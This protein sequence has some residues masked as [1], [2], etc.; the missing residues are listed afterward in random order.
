MDKLYAIIQKTPVGQKAALL[1]L[2]LALMVGGYYFLGYQGQ[3]DELDRLDRQN[4]QLEEEL[5]EKK[6]IA[7]NITR[8]QKRVEFL[9]QRLEEKKKNLPEDANMDQLL[10]TLNELSEKSDMRIIKFTPQSEVSKQFYAE[11][12]VR[13]E[14]EGNY[15]EIATFFDKIS[16]EDRI[17]NISDI[18]LGKPELRNGKVVLAA[19]CL[20]KTFRTVQEQ[21]GAPAGA[22]GAPG[23]APAPGA[24]K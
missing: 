23:A 21:P 5:E 16:K 7:N 1:G 22:P 9:R 6:E 4:A 14:I 13:M 24:P 12:P 20:A 19:T 8:F 17:I 11:I 10:K 15:H 3:A 2:V 18:V